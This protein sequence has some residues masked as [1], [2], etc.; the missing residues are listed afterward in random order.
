MKLLNEKAES[1]REL[2]QLLKKIFV[3]LPFST[4]CGNVPSS[5]LYDSIFQFKL[6]FNDGVCSTN[7]VTSNGAENDSKSN[8]NLINEDAIFWNELFEKNQLDLLRLKFTAEN[9]TRT[10]TKARNSFSL[11]N[12]ANVKGQSDFSIKKEKISFLLR[13][14]QRI[15]DYAQH[16]L[17]MVLINLSFL[18]EMREQLD[19]IHFFERE[20]VVLLSHL[21]L[22]N[23]KLI[24]N[25]FHSPPISSNKLI[26]VG[27]AIGEGKELELVKRGEI[28]RDCCFLLSWWILLV[29]E[30]QD[31]VLD[32]I[33]KTKGGKGKQ[34]LF[35]FVQ[36]MSQTTLLSI[37]FSLDHVPAQSLSSLHDKVSSTFMAS[38]FQLLGSLSSLKLD[39]LSSVREESVSSQIQLL[40]KKRK[41]LI[42]S[43][44]IQTV[45]S[46]IGYMLLNTPTQQLFKTYSLVLNLWRQFEGESPR[47]DLTS[48]QNA[49]IPLKTCNTVF[50]FFKFVSQEV[51]KGKKS[52]EA[53]ETLEIISNAIQDN[54]LEGNMPTKQ[55]CLFASAGLIHSL[56]SLP[57]TLSPSI[58]NSL[59]NS[60]DKLYEVGLG[61]L[62][63]IGIGLIG[64]K[65]EKVWV[66]NVCLFFSFTLHSI[67]STK[68]RIHK[69]VQIASD[70]LL[71]NSL[72]I[73][74]ISNQ[75]N[76]QE[77]SLIFFSHHFTKLLAHLFNCYGEFQH[78][79]LEKWKQFSVQIFNNQ[80][81]F[82]LMETESKLSPEKE[83]KLNKLLQTCFLNVS[84]FMFQ[85]EKQLKPSQLIQIIFIL[86][87]LNFCRKN[88]PQYENFVNFLAK[89]MKEDD[90]QCTL[91]LEEII[92][93]GGEEEG[94]GR[95]KVLEGTRRAFL[96]RMSEEIIYK[97][98]LP[99]LDLLTQVVL[100]CISTQ[101]YLREFHLRSHF[102]FSKLLERGD[103]LEKNWSFKF[104]PYYIQTS[105]SSY[106]DFTPLSSLS[107]FVLSFS[108]LHTTHLVTQHN[109]TN[110]NHNSSNSNRN[111]AKTTESTKR[112]NWSVE[113]RSEVGAIFLFIFRALGG[114]VVELVEREFKENKESGEEKRL[115][116]FEFM[117]KMCDVVPID[118]LP[119]LFSTI[120]ALLFSHFPSYLLKQALSIIRKIVIDCS[121]QTRKAAFVEWFKNLRERSKQLQSIKPLT[122]P[123]L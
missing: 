115:A 58:S 15:S 92:R 52:E 100:N 103:L 93:I 60:I 106:P 95:R 68:E 112:L 116:L 113:S 74:A 96:L 56:Y 65:E 110:S 104:I 85:V 42:L 94:K 25:F 90:K 59:Q 66:W 119:L 53:V 41:Q 117:V 11:A 73:S 37:Q 87:N 78:F 21:L 43:K 83:R 122:T 99:E 86:S 46:G 24:Q 108:N 1:S 26:Q 62:E 22:E 105:L 5:I 67:K 81:I 123:K 48:P 40:E 61:G 7:K 79:I 34:N 6:R 12:S 16:S 31:K 33:W 38:S 114:K 17:E 45:L 120:E 30:S 49:L 18:C 70:T 9:S 109:S 54:F 118:M 51:W 4:L 64:E 19:N 3:S 39:S 27:N 28:V 32:Q 36:K 91:L 13:R 76:E 121:D 107:F 101:V 57:K 63:I 80:V 82:E 44:Q 2:K 14:F 69:L 47:K 102:V 8:Q 98:D 29:N 72:D 97:L 77:E 84:Q 75:D 89:Q 88:N 50:E 20:N 23:L 35:E 55:V 111:S 71:A 10:S